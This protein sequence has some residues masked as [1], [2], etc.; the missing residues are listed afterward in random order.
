VPRGDLRLTLHDGETL[1]IPRTDVSRV[2]GNL[3]QLD[4]NPDAVVMAAVVTAVSRDV[5]DRF[6]L[7]LTHRQSALIRQ[8]VARP[9]LDDGIADAV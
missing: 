9:E 7:K 4:A 6:P 1:T 2:C 3:W 8:A 5:F